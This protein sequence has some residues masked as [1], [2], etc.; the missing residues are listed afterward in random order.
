[1][2]NRD[3]EASPPM[4]TNR[5]PLNEILQS[6][7]SSVYTQQRSRCEKENPK[8]RGDNIEHVRSR[9]HLSRREKWPADKNREIRRV[10]FARR[11][12]K[13]N[14]VH[15]S[16]TSPRIR[17]DKRKSG[18]EKER[19]RERERG[20][21]YI[22][23]KRAYFSDVDFS[24]RGKKRVT[25]EPRSFATNIYKCSFVIAAAPKLRR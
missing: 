22:R 5:I 23:L 6:T 18:R 8:K 17:R 15:R 20:S 16:A 21:A 9:I 1:M 25:A 11:R 19:E 12:R 4:N 7:C 13:P 14:G 3:N 2:I 24:P 10:E